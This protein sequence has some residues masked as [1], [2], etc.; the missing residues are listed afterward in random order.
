[1]I[2]VPSFTVR[3]VADEE[4]VSAVVVGLVAAIAPQMRSRIDE[5]G[6]V[7]DVDRSRRNTPDEHAGGKLRSR[8]R[9]HA[10]KQGARQGGRGNQDPGGE[11]DS[12][13]VF[14]EPDVERVAKQIAGISFRHVTGQHVVS[15]ERDPG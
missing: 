15:L 4:I 14:V 1:M 3:K 10:R 6:D 2:V 8:W 7:P 5:G 9:A 12:L 13:P 11:G